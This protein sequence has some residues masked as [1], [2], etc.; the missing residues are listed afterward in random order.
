[1]KLAKGETHVKGWDYA[2]GFRA[3]LSGMEYG[4]VEVT[5][6]RLITSFTNKRGYTR[7]EIYLD[8]VTAVELK[9]GSFFDWRLLINVIFTFVLSILSFLSFLES[10]V[11]SFMSAYRVYIFALLCIDV[12][13]LVLRILF[14]RKIQIVVYV[15]SEPQLFAYANTGRHSGLKKFKLIIVNKA[16]ARDLYDTLTSTMLDAKVGVYA[17]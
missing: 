11:F 16:V 10:S 4:R 1:M 5:N 3:G 12:I 14:N 6:K 17:N 15:T 13:I 7:D 2:K 8:T 9:Q